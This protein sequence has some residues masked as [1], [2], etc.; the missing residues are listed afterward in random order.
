MFKYIGIFVKFV[1]NK[2]DTILNYLAGFCFIVL[3]LTVAVQSSQL[4]SC[5]AENALI[6]QELKHA[7]EL[8]EI[9]QSYANKSIERNNIEYR[10]KIIYIDKVKKD[11]NK[12][13]CDNAMY[14]LRANF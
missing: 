9:K 4:K 12:S 7:K 8:Q 6:K 2:F 14:L 10:D 1:K 11:E 13:D 5:K 3:L